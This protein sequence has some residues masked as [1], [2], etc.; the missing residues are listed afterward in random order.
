MKCSRLSL[1]I[2]NNIPLKEPH[3]SLYY[4]VVTIA[5]K[6]LQDKEPCFMLNSSLY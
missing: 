2:V 4:N 3:S 1:E 5:N 6:A